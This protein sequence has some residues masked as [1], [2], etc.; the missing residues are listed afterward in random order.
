MSWFMQTFKYTLKSVTLNE[1][2]DVSLNE[3]ASLNLYHSNLNYHH[4]YILNPSPP[5]LFFFMGFVVATKNDL[6][7][8]SL[9]LNHLSAEMETSFTFGSIYKF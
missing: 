8:A 5:I 3:C 6:N 4:I 7:L 1:T 2:C 9:F